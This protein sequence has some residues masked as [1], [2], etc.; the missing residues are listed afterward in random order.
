MGEPM[1]L[2]KR[3]FLHVSLGEVLRIGRPFRALPLWGFV[4]QGFYTP[5]NKERSP[6]PRVHPG[7]GYVAP[8][9]LG[10][11]RLLSVLLMS[12][13][14]PVSRKSS[15]LRMLSAFPPRLMAGGPHVS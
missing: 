4:T 6:G 7:L 5:A 10:S 11:V 12:S 2:T 1:P 15:V 14:L 3:G 8:L 9:G 13:A